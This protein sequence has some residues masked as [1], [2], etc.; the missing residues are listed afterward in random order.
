MDKL[1]SDGAARVDD[2]AENVAGLV[3]RFFETLSSEWRPAKDA[4]GDPLYDFVF[5]NLSDASLGR[6]QA[7]PLK[8][9]LAWAPGAEGAEL[10]GPGKGGEQRRC[11][12]REELRGGGK[13]EGTFLAG[14]TGRSSELPA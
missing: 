8:E 10:A 7:L 11:L 1:V 2:A 14:G 6:P 9:I 3:A 5:E 4:A 12:L 13:E